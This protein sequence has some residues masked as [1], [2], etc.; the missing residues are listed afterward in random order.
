MDD[1]NQPTIE[2]PKVIGE[3]GPTPLGTRVHPMGGHPSD[4]SSDKHMPS[5]MLR[6][7]Y[8][9]PQAAG[10]LVAPTYRPLTTQPYPAS[11]PR[12]KKGFGMSTWAQADPN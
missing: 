8:R 9:I 10:A 3:M 11:E 4:S 6:L 1:S 2:D 5:H 7:T 12:M